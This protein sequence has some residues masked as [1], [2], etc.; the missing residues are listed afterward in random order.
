V[1]V[2]QLGQHIAQ[3]FEQ[4]LPGHVG[5]DVF[6]IPIIDFIPIEP[7]FLS[8]IIKKAVMLVHHLPQGL[9]IAL[10]SVGE[11]FFTDASSRQEEE[12]T[13]DGDK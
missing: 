5:S 2:A 8:F 1:P 12:H 6:A 13:Y 7:I 10:G 3:H 11:L 4:S 9:E